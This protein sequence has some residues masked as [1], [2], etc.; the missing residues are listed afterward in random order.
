MD[1]EKN[2]LLESIKTG[3]INEDIESDIFF[4]PKIITNDYEKKEKVLASI[5]FLL[6]ECDEFFFNVAFVTKSGVLSLFNT[7]KKI[8]RLGIK[9]KILISKYQNFS[10]PSALRMLMK[11]SNIDL[12]LIDENN[13]H[14]K[15][16]LFKTKDNYELIIGSSNLTQDALS[17]NTEYNLKLSLSNKSKL[18]KEAISIFQKYFLQGINLTEDFL[19]N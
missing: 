18:A 11:F 9:G 13:F 17:K 6:Q 5:D 8:E 10:D 2:I 7:F 3:L 16:Y 12:R 1:F 14:A 15:G 4:Q 19:C